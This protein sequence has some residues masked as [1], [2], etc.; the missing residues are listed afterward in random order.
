MA[1]LIRVLLRTT[2]VI[3][4]LLIGFTSGW[5]SAALVNS[6][7]AVPTPIKTVAHATGVTVPVGP[8]DARAKFDVF[9]EIWDLL[10]QEYYSRATLNQTAMIQG[11]IRGMLASLDDKYTVYQEPELAAQT[12][13]H[14]Q[15]TL[16]GIGTYLRITAGHAFLYKPFRDGPAY[17]AG[18]RQ[19]DELLMI[20]G[21]DVPQLIAGL[22]TSDAAVK[23]A[24]KL[25]GAE[26]SAVSLRV[27]KAAD[28]SDIELALVRRNIVIPS[29][30]GQRFEDGIVYLRINE[31]KATTPKE[32]DQAYAE[33]TRTAPRGIILDLRNNPGGFLNSA[34]E[35]LGRFYSGTALYEDDGV[36]GLQEITTIVGGIMVPTAVPVVIL[37]N[38][39][40][41]SAS[42]IVAGALAERRPA[43]ML[44]GEKTFGKGSVQN[45]HRL[46][47]GGSARITIAHWITPEQRTIHAVGITP[48]QVVPFADDPTSMAPCTGDRQPAIGQ[49]L[50]GDTQLFAAIQLL[51]HK[52]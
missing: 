32:Y 48:Q 29:V 42:E 26:G 47:D 34:Q 49:T 51:T 12:Q 50:C 21:E 10:D 43:T 17:L 11:A 2:I 30:E 19:D 8:E 20:D 7:V 18:L 1:L 46:S 37:V 4:L 24:G 40:S 9:W 41:A 38:G 52:P 5:L 25:R 15:G 14:L 6:G 44:L 3:L 16:G 33:L 27:R 23:V 13:D 36:G 31:F 28:A 35:I 22:S 45:I 39:G